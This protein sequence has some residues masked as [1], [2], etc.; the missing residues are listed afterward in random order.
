MRLERMSRNL[1]FSGHPSNVG[2]CLQAHNGPYSTRAPHESVIGLRLETPVNLG[3]RNPSQTETEVEA[4]DLTLSDHGVS[5]RHYGSPRSH[6]SAAAG[7]KARRRIRGSRLAG[8][9]RDQRGYRAQRDLLTGSTI[10]THSTV[11]SADGGH[12]SNSHFGRQDECVRGRA[13]AVH[14]SL[15]ETSAA[16]RALQTCSQWLGL[17]LQLRDSGANANAIQDWCPRQR[18]QRGA[19]VAGT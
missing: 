10:G 1:C 18:Q 17:H 16:G 3:G 5:R 13:M 14:G 2:R 8:F 15:I 6:H 12:E 9:T 19:G 11:A 7:A 4:Q